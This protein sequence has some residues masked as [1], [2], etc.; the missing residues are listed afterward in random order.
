MTCPNF[1]KGLKMAF[2]PLGI[3]QREYLIIKMS[4]MVDSFQ[5]SRLKASQLV[6]SIFT[7]QKYLCKNC[8]SQ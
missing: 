1:K 6:T 2:G 4:H 3:K 5:C 7:L 8:P